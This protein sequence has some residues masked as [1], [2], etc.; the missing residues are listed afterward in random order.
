MEEAVES[1]VV[2]LQSRV[3]DPASDT[4]KV[5]TNESYDKTYDLQYP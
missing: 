1:S 4:L 2:V 3:L 5:T